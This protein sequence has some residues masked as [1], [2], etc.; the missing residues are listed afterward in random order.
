MQ[1]NWQQS[2]WPQFSFD[3]QL[4]QSYEAAFMRQTGVM[5]GAIKHIS[6]IEKQALRIELISDEALC[7]SEIEGEILNRESVQSSLRR[8]L[9]VPT[10][11]RASSPAE[12]GISEMMID[13]YDHVES[14]LS[15]QTL[16]CWHRLL[17]K[18]RNDLHESGEYRQY[19]DP[20]Q[21]VSGPIHS[22]KIHF[23][24]PPSSSVIKEMTR[25]NRWFNLPRS[26]STPS[27]ETL[28][29]A[30]I[31][32]W[33]FV[34][35]HPFED[36]NGRL[37]RALSAKSLAQ[38]IEQP[39]IL[40]LSRTI[41]QKKK[42]YY[43][44]LE[45]SNKHNDITAYLVYFSEM[46]L[47]AQNYTQRMVDFVIRKTKLYDRVKGTLNPRQEKVIDRMFREGLEG[48]K[49]GLSAQNYISLTQA[50]RAT[51]TRDLQDL[52][53]K[54]VLQKSGTLKSTR[55]ALNL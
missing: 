20:M 14:P 46:V 34:C 24:A 41:Q 49:G 13:L 37:A 30:G 39:I 4:L 27:F 25:Y 28:I 54:G 16:F 50:P 53:E 2:D 45:K 47:D 5:I 51:T 52:V 23:E 12:Q 48:F 9:G 55:Y 6:D 22:P 15:D 43:D 44:I 38:G 31:A 7:T 40:S 21:V 18:G 42:A 3:K 8:M 29:H 36:G 17:M 10:D 33:H 32:H 35:I 11:T 19:E 26:R 1:W